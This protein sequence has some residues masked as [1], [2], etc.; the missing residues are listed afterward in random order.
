MRTGGLTGLTV[1]AFAL[2]A[3]VWMSV[4]I[5]ASR[6]AVEAPP[7]AD[8]HAQHASMVEQMRREVTPQMVEEMN[9]PQ[10]REMR[11]PGMIAQM[12]AHQRESDRL[13][14]RR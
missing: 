1:V 5:G 3:A 2:L 10:W 8:V 9:A 7:S 4:A 11:Q 13:L 12:E 14:G 6:P